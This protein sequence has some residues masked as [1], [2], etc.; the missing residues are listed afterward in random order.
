MPH[1]RERRGPDDTPVDDPNEL[2]QPDTQGR[3]LP[4][5][6]SDAIEEPEPD[7]SADDPG[8]TDGRDQVDRP[9]GDPDAGAEPS[10]VMREAEAGAE[11]EER[12]Q[13]DGS[14]LP[15]APASGRVDDRV[16]VGRER[17]TGPGPSPIDP[18]AT[19][20]TGGQS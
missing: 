18:G 4:R 20:L 15:D 9:S 7:V 5:P 19:D 6:S 2:P 17:G 14:G 8:M 13:L 3:E 10:L 1:M 12:S 11:V 16:A